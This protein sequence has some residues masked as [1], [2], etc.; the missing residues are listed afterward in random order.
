MLGPQGFTVQQPICEALPGTRF[1]GLALHKPTTSQQLPRVPMKARF[2]TS[3]L[4]GLCL[5]LAAVAVPGKQKAA[6]SEYRQRPVT[7][8]GRR[9]VTPAAFWISSADGVRRVPAS[10]VEVASGRS[11]TG[12]VD[13]RTDATRLWLRESH[14]TA[15]IIRPIRWDRVVRAQVGEETFSG[16]EFR[17]AIV[18]AREVV[19]KGDKVRLGRS[20]SIRV[21]AGGPADSPAAESRVS[22][23]GSDAMTTPGGG[24]RAAVPVRSLALDARVANWDADVEVDGLV[25]QVRPLDASQAVVPVRGTLEVSLT[26]W[27]A[28]TANSK[29][30]SARLGRW[31]Q[32]VGPTDFGLSG[33]AYRLPFQAAHPEYD[34]RWAPYGAVHARLS[35]PGVGVFEVTESDVRVRPYSATRDYLQQTTGG[36]FFPLERTGRGRR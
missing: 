25:V 35:I 22:G 11:F 31:S 29:Q 28:A 13:L 6:A 21:H 34:L 8:A 23:R 33:A 9:L 3:T 1:A 26:G 36:R 15:V 32:L 24:T 30:Y 17:K 10:T 19:P 18:Q 16:A 14:G 20:G 5:A 27:R 12:D 7:V 4:F 2:S